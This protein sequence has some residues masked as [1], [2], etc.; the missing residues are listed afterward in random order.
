MLQNGYIKLHRSITK[1]ELWQDQN[2]F[3]LFITLLLMANV[4]DCEYQGVMVHRGE[5]C[6]SYAKL[7]QM[8]GLTKKQIRIALEKLEGARCTARYSHP[9]FLVI[10]IKNYNFYQEKGTIKGTIKEGHDKGHEKGHKKGH[11]VKTMKPACS[12][13]YRGCQNKKGHDEGHSLGH[14]KGQHNKKKYEKGV[15]KD[16]PHKEEKEKIP[17]PWANSAWR[18]VIPEGWTEEEFIANVMELSK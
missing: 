7:E 2:A 1:W 9:K 13:V 4:S 14:E 6:A 17:L 8:T 11:D 3:R 10:S 15:S 5:V 16:T 18:P 12:T